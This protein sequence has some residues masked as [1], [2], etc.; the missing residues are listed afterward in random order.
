MNLNRN[1]TFESIVADGSRPLDRT[2]CQ[3]PA[4]GEGPLADGRHTGRNLD[5][6]EPCTITESSVRNLCKSVPFKSHI[7]QPLASR[8]GELAHSL[9][10]LGQI[11]VGQVT[12]IEECALANSC[13]AVRHITVPH[14]GA[15]ERTSCQYRLCGR[16]FGFSLVPPYDIIPEK[17]HRITDILWI[18][19][20]VQQ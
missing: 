19:H 13:N 20:G 10:I 17:P 6:K 15:D 18:L 3:V 2:F 9:Q 1:T 5:V 8:E 11:H 14:L 7:A 16:T 4:S 12:A